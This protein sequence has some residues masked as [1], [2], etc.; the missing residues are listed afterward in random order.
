M[1]R[2]SYAKRAAILAHPM[3]PHM[4]LFVNRQHYVNWSIKQADEIM[5]YLKIW[6]SRSDEENV[7]QAQHFKD[8][9]STVLRVAL[10]AEYTWVKGIGQ[11]HRDLMDWL[12]LLENLIDALCPGLFVNAR[13]WNYVAELP[14]PPLSYRKAKP[15]AQRKAQPKA[16]PQ[17]KRVVKPKAKPVSKPKAKSMVKPKAKPLVKSKAKP[18]IPPMPRLT[19]P[20]CSEVITLDPPTPRLVFPSCS[21]VITL[22]DSIAEGERTM[23]FSSIWGEPTPVQQLTAELEE[24]VL[25]D[26]PVSLHSFDFNDTWM[27]SVNFKF[28]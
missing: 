1:P 5:Q 28:N 14:E 11:D 23:D 25:D 8:I 7:K 2:L 26:G 22:D 13:A 24:M 27:P 9:V 4:F 16:K 3:P 21:E 20:S 10:K 19:F 15:K 6:Q 12:Q 18:V 17:V